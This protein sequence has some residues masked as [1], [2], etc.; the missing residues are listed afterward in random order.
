M[1]KAEDI[2]LPVG[3]QAFILSK[4]YYGALTKSLEKLGIER[5]F[6]VLYFLHNNKNCCQQVICDN[7]KIDKTAMVKVMDYL[8]KAGWIERKTNPNDR[9]E[10]FISL[11]KKG[12]KQTKEV[13]RSFKIIDEKAFSDINETERKAF[14]KIMFKVCEN[15]EQ[16]PSDNLTFNYKKSK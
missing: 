5:Y 12:E 2:K 3:T 7:L 15:L 16:L 14:F 6:S 4:M 9:R 11:S 1:S 10:H 8:S 13:V